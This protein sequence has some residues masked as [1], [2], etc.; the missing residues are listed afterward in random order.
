MTIDTNTI[1]AINDLF[2]KGVSVQKVSKQFG[3][4]AGY[5]MFNVD[6][7]VLHYNG[8]AFPGN[9]KKVDIEKL[10]EAY[11]RGDSVL[12]MSKDFNVSRRSIVERL[13]YL[14]YNIRNGS[15]ANIIRFKNSTIEYRQQ[16]T[17]KAHDAV[18]GVKRSFAK[19]CNCA[20]LREKTANKSPETYGKLGPGEIELFYALRDKNLNPIMQKAFQIYNIDIFV[21][22]NI[23]IEIASC[24]FKGQIQFRKKFCGDTVKRFRRKAKEITDSK[25][26][27]V[28]INFRDIDILKIYA[29]DIVA[30]I[31]SLRTNPSASGKYFVFSC[32][33]KIGI[34]ARDVNKG[35]FI[36]GPRLK[37]PFREIKEVDILNIC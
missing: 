13:K 27:F 20:I 14:G 26:I 37:Y 10:K 8:K 1:N 15:E 25:G 30:F 33:Y 32:Y 31:D 17:K 28:E 35:T 9:Y 21:A 36:A 4:T 29:D 12:K 16:I 5:I 18:R 6:L 19:E 23:F 2:A 24:M 7:G 34:P 3:I 22:P 11:I